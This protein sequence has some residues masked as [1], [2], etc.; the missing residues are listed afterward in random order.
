[1]T[2]RIGFICDD[3]QFYQTAE[4]DSFDLQKSEVNAH[5]QK[6]GHTDYLVIRGGNQ[7][8]AGRISIDDRTRFEKIKDAILSKI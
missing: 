6:T 4:A 5:Y 8:S 1:M 7:S 3:C 2:E